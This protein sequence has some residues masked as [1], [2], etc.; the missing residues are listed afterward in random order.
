[1]IPLLLIGF[2]VFFGFVLALTVY[3]EAIY[4]VGGNY[5]ASWLSGM[6]VRTIVASA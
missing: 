1:M 5:D 6:R 4:S 2:L 3:G